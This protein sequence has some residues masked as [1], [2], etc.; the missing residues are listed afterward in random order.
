MQEGSE[1]EGTPKEFKPKK[2]SFT[3]KVR[4]VDEITPREPSQAASVP[5]RKG[6]GFAANP[7]MDSKQ[8][9]EVVD[10]NNEEEEEDGEVS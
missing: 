7:E 9:N 4:I 10:E 2:L 1:E 6:V 8:E 5:E 3:E